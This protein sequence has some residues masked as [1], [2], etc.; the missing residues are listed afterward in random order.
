MLKYIKQNKP[1]VI[2][3]IGDANTGK[4][5]LLYWL[6]HS[7]KGYEFKAYQYGLR[8][9]VEGVKSVYS[10]SE[11]ENVKNSLVIVDEMPSLFDLDNRKE[12]AKIEKM[13]R[14]IYHNNNILILCG[15]PENF[16][17]FISGRLHVEV[18]KAITIADL[19]N[20]SSVKHHI[21]QY[22]G[23]ELGSSVLA[24][25]KDEALVYDGTHYEKIH[26]PYMEQYDTKKGNKPILRECV[27]NSRPLSCSSKDSI[28]VE[29]KKSEELCIELEV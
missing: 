17:K 10:V 16:K 11:L 1:I 19:I 5:N 4:S 6:L 29:K 8:L 15:L 18:Y 27:E 25:D 26:I 21:T 20:G 22:K 13:L 12:K 14:L 9:N 28:F 7:L 24:L 3:V 2:S 23:N